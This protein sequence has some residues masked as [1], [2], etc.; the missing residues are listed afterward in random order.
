[1]RSQV[2][3]ISWVKRRID[4][5]NAAILRRVLSCLGFAE[6]V[7]RRTSESY[8][9]GFVFTDVLKEKARLVYMVPEA[10]IGHCG[11]FTEDYDVLINVN[12]VDFATMAEECERLLDQLA[13]D[14]L[15]SLALWK[16]EGYGNKEIAD[17]LQCAPRS[18]GRKL[19]RIRS[20]WIHEGF[21]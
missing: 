4:I 21:P 20:I 5:T 1:M 3:R 18:V 7:K 17:L 6:A 11:V 16:M 15:R 12:V 14:E 19:Q 9:F 8:E 2:S 10:S 13:D